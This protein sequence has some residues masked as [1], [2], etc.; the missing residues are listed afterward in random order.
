MPALLRQQLLRLVLER[1]PGPAT[2][3]GGAGAARSSPSSAHCT[4]CVIYAHHTHCTH[5]THRSA[6]AAPAAPPLP[7]AP[8]YAPVV[9]EQDNQDREP[10]PFGSTEYL[11]ENVL[12]R[13]LEWA[14]NS[15][16]LRGVR[17]RAR[18]APPTVLPTLMRAATLPIGH[19][20]FTRAIQSRDA[21]DA[22][23]PKAESRRRCQGGPGRCRRR[24]IF[25]STRF[26]FYTAVSNP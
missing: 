19:G 4:H 13:P 20:R 7:S 25:L 8:P 21:A 14:Y 17:L 2:D 12:I 18:T 26:H 5:H 9:P 1:P 22:C 23:R 24:L 3:D 15:R 16:A 11:R 10:H 6:P